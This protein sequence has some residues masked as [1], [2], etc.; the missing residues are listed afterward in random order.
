MAALPPRIGLTWRRGAG[1]SRNIA[2][3]QQTGGQKNLLFILA[4]PLYTPAFMGMHPWR[5][6]D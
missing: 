6:P 3:R 2:I 1:Q 5:M 4:D